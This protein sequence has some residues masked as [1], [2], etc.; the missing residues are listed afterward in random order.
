VDFAVVEYSPMLHQRLKA[1]S[2]TMTGVPFVLIFRKRELYVIPPNQG[3]AAIT[4][5]GLVGILQDLR[6]R[7]TREEGFNNVGST[8]NFH[9]A[10]M[11]GPSR[12]GVLPP[13]LAAAAAAPQRQMANP[14]SFMSNRA[15]PDVGTSDRRLPEWPISVVKNKPWNSDR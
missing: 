14:A 7:V 3:G 10:A 9:N 11:Y 4:K 2:V 6:K 13:P 8:L 5:D 12:G 1:A 15:M